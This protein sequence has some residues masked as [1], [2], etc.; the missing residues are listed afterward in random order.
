[1]K[2]DDELIGLKKN[3]SEYIVPVK[4]FECI[5]KCAPTLWALLYVRSWKL[6]NNPDSPCVI[7]TIWACLAFQK[8][9]T[10]IQTE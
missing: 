5:C 10:Y 9:P 8:H 4:Q 3:L 7:I 1:M 6:I 2:Y